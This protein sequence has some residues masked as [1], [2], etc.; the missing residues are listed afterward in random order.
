MQFQLFMTRSSHASSSEPSSM[1]SPR[2]FMSL[3]RRALGRASL[4]SARSHLDRL[5]EGF[6]FRDTSALREDLCRLSAPLRQF[7]LLHPPQFHPLDPLS[8]ALGSL[9]RFG[10]NG[11][12]LLI[13]V[14]SPEP[15]VVEPSDLSH[16]SLV[17]QIAW[18]EQ[19][20]CRLI[21]YNASR[22][23]AMALATEAQ[24]SKDPSGSGSSNR[25]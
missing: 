12:L 8:H 21:A 25:L 22:L 19:S 20:L 14:L 13:E 10:W 6:Y 11:Q 3:S 9:P 23:E 24:G 4:L 17:D 1:S 18:H 15:S 2:A 16:R 5:G 7:E